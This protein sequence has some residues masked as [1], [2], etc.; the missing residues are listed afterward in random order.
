MC[1]NSRALTPRLLA[2]IGAA[3]RRRDATRLREAAHKLHGTISAF[4]M[5]AG[6]AASDLEDLAAGGLLDEAEALA[7]RVGAMVRGLLAEM[8]GISIGTIKVRAGAT[9]APDGTASY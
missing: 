4:F 7:P 5:Q 9:G 6:V 8:D 2:E 1:R 3:L